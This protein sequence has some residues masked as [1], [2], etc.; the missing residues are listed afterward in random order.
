MNPSKCEKRA[1]CNVCGKVRYTSKLIK[2]DG[3]SY[4]RKSN[5]LSS[6][7]NEVYIKIEDTESRSTCISI[8][9]C[10]L[11]LISV[12]KDRACEAINLHNVLID[13]LFWTHSGNTNLKLTLK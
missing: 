10:Q 3:H 2:F 7:K 1:K 4:C 13:R 5:S 6:I 9:K 12:L 8:T 11:Q